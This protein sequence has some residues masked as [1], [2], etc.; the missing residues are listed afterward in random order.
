MKGIS[1]IIDFYIKYELRSKNKIEC[2]IRSVE[3]I[4]RHRKIHKYEIKFQ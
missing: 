1:R 4:S 3:G 2:T